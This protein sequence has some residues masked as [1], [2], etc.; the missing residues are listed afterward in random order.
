MKSRHLIGCVVVLAIGSI[1]PAH[2]QQQGNFFGM[3]HTGLG[4]A[5]L[6]G[7]AE[8]RRHKLANPLEQPDSLWRS[9]VVEDPL[10]H[11]R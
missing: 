1:G 3:D 9:A 2:A 7:V 8:L 4:Q 5:L 6:D 11:L 10:E